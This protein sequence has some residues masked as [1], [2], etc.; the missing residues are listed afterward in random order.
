MARADE[1]FECY[2]EKLDLGAWDDV[3][4]VW[5]ASSGVWGM[6]HWIRNGTE[7]DKC[8]ELNLQHFRCNPEELEETIAHELVHIHLAERHNGLTGHDNEFCREMNKLGFRG[9]ATKRGLND[10]PVVGIGR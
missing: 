6:A 9:D 3:G 1:L 5:G 10:K 8:I 7:E 4:L 2:C